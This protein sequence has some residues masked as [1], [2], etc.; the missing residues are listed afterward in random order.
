MSV[1]SKIRKNILKQRG[2]ELAKHTRKPI[3]VDDLPS[4]FRKTSLMRYIELKHSAHL[5]DL[6]MQGN[7]YELG[8]QLGVSAS[9]ISKWRK[10]INEAFW[11]NFE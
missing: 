1:Q 3:T 4:S 8:K 6:I 5:E 10:A 9:T 11:D 2:V 7:I